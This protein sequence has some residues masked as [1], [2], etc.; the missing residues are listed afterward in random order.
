MNSFLAIRKFEELQRKYDEEKIVTDS[1]IL[2]LKH[3]VEDAEQKEKNS[4]NKLVEFESKVLLFTHH[5]PL[6]TTATT[7]NMIEINQSLKYVIVSSINR[8]GQ[9]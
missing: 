8:T 4:S 1:L 3:R 5:S 2:A 6:P 9:R 7:S